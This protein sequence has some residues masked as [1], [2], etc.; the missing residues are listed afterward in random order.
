VHHGSTLWRTWTPLRPS[1]CAG[2]HSPSRSGWPHGYHHGR[3]Q[4]GHYH[5]YYHGYHHG[6]YH[7]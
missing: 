5:G 1:C 4:S 2:P 7:E 6:Y 3:L